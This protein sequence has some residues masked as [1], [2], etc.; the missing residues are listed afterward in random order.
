MFYPTFK[1]NA[2]DLL[3]TDMEMPAMTGLELVKRTR[4]SDENKSIPIISMPSST[5]EPAFYLA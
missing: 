1:K 5:Y 2:I 3:I 4:S